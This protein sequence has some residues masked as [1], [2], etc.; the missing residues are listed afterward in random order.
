MQVIWGVKKWS[1]K[2]FP[3][4]AVVET[5][6]F[7]EGA[8]IPGQATEIPHA[9]WHVAKKRERERDGLLKLNSRE[10]FVHRG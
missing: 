8:W 2:D 7:S 4:A 1:I 10:S 3:G 9:M 5:S 6:H